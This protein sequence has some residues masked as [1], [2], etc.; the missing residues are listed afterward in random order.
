MPGEMPDTGMG[1]LA[2]VASIPVGNAF[3][4]SAMLLG[5]GYVVIRRR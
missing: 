4:G 2:P 5:A 1:G 3:A